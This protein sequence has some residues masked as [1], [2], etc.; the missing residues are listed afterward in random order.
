MQTVD[1]IACSPVFR[2]PLSKVEGVLEVKEL[3]ITNKIVVVFDEAKLERE[4]LREEIS[5]IAEKA[6]LGGKIIFAR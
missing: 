3:P 5:R 1:C 2:R 4:R 6:G